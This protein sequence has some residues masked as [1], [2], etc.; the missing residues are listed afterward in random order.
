MI[1]F[2]LGRNSSS[3]NTLTRSLR[4]AAHLLDH[5]AGDT[6]KRFAQSTDQRF[7]DT[8]KWAWHADGLPELHGVSLARLSGSIVSF[9]A[10]GDNLLALCRVDTT[11]RRE[12]RPLVHHQGG[13]H[14]LA[15]LG[16][17]GTAGAVASPRPRDRRIYL[18]AFDMCCIGHQSPGLWTHPF[19]K[20]DTYKDLEYWTNLAQLL[21][22]GGFDC[23]FLADVLGTYDV[24]K[25][26]R[27]TAIA[28]ATQVPVNDPTIP[29]SA[30]AAVTKKLGFGITVSLT[31]E[32]PYA[33]ARRMSTLDHL[34][35]GRVAWNVVTGYL[36][37]AA[38]NLG[39]TEQV[40]HDER[41]NIAEEFIEV[42][43]K[44]WEGS[45]EQDAV[46][47]DRRKGIY[48]DPAKVHDINHEGKYFKVPGAHLCE[49]SP[50]RTPFIFQAGASPKG[51]SFGGRH[52]EAVFISGPTP[53][54]LKKTVA[55]VRK[56]AVDAGR[57]PYA[58]KVFT[59]VTIITGATDEEAQAKYDDLKQFV[60]IDGALTLYGGW[61]G[62]DLSQ[63]PLD[64]PL[65]YVE[66]DSIRS[67]NR[68]WSKQSGIEDEWTARKVGE[69]IAIG[70]LGPLLVG[71]GKT[72]AK[73]LEGESRAFSVIFRP[74][75]PR[76]ICSSPPLVLTWCRMGGYYGRR[77]IQLGLRHVAWHV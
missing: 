10:A 38:L 6:A 37:S 18:N 48:A 3:L 36:K 46:V 15:P 42:T 13:Y 12:G 69:K 14:T 75:F 33:F 31:Y 17:A 52:A 27:D 19:D 43:Y 47:K 55:S 68:M 7:V 30:M 35:K 59:L 28:T 72:V 62:V 16:A 77:R 41:Y 29:I 8:S 51:Q 9:S 76:F 20:A 24:Y 5:D 34:T 53:A 71:S 65:Q 61:A 58:I 39:L 32:L 1:T 23:L 40:E 11:V 56:S 2:N 54:Y 63:V 73:T 22:K 4:F 67:V 70:G 21:E 25:G 66:N 60:S 74:F 44:L 50:Q 45:W 64:Q 57:D 49:P 26:T